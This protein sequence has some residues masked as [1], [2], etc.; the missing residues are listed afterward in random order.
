MYTSFCLIFIK[1]I[2]RDQ[3]AH[4]SEMG[5]CFFFSFLNN[6]IHQNKITGTTSHVSISSILFLFFLRWESLRWSD[7]KEGY[8]R[9]ILGKHGMECGNG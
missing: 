1:S 9:A 2:K 7:M 8:V 5:Y 4:L 6:L 3:Q